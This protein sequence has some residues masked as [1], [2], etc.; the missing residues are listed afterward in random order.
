MSAPG[1]LSVMSA[2]CALNA[3][4]SFWARAAVNGFHP[5]SACHSQD[6]STLFRLD[7]FSP[8]A[9]ELEVV[10]VALK[11]MSMKYFRT[12]TR[13]KMYGNSAMYFW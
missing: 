2:L 10:L 13:V 8:L 12:R 4:V 1:T 5:L 11:C 3:S 6:I 7:S 9:D